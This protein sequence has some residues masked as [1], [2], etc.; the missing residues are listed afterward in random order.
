MCVCARACAVR[1][2]L[3]VAREGKRSRQDI[4]REQVSVYIYLYSR[5]KSTYMYIHV[6][7]CVKGDFEL[8]KFYFN[9]FLSF[10]RCSGW[11]CFCPS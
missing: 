6:Y 8:Q 11:L 10:F 3:S 4:S 7:V 9:E 2:L 1:S 5:F